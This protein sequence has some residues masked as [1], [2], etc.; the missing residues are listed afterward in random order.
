MGSL[1]GGNLP[2]AR[3]KDV[4]MKILMFSLDRGVLVAGS[5]QQEK[6]LEYAHFAE[7][8]HVVLF[9]FG[10]RLPREV[11]ISSF[12]RVY[13]TGHRF[14]FN[15]YYFLR[16]FLV[17]RRVVSEK[18]FSSA[19]D[20]LTAQDAFPTGL[21]AYAVRLWT[22]IPLQIQVHIDFFKARFRRESFLNRLSAACADFLLPRADAVRAVSP[23]IAA[24]LTGT[25]RIPANRVSVLPTFCDA[26]KWAAAQSVFDLRARYPDRDFIVLVLGRL[27]PQKNVLMVLR[28]AGLL[29]ATHP[30]MAFI[31]VGSGPEE[32]RLRSLASSSPARDSIFFEL[33]ADDPVSY[34]KGADL[35]MFPSW[36]EGWGLALIEA[37]ACALPVIATPVGCAPL[38]VESGKNGYIIPQDDAHAAAAH[39]S[40][41]YSHPEERRAMGSA[42]QKAAFEK[43]PQDKALY[44][45]AHRA[46]FTQALYGK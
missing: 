25:L 11:R 9:Y 33:W 43:F 35:F 41:L 4:R 30:R 45:A 16:A 5:R 13:P 26:A 6:L 40:F 15:P 21:A 44:F 3:K 12:L 32:D 14:R 42:A 24:Y 29:A 36:Y 28:M 7:E 2:F 37:M 10:S 23:E 17:G 20:V 19:R 22:G 38:L 27:V 34:Y 31:I 8:L 46:A 18:G 39:A 1:S